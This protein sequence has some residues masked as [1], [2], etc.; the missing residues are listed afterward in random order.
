M[1]EN[2]RLAPHCTVCY[3]TN[4][5][6]ELDKEFTEFHNNTPIIDANLEKGEVF[7]YYYDTCMRKDGIAVISF[8]DY[9]DSEHTI[10]YNAYIFDYG[11]ILFFTR[12]IHS[13]QTN[14]AS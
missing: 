6:P 8:K 7:G 2:V 9:P 14:K 10:N 11:A 12:Y 5:Y 4:R 13:N 3:A 1:S